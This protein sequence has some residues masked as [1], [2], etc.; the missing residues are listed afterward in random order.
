MRAV[1]VVLMLALPSSVP[2]QQLPSFTD[3]YFFGASN[4]DT[5]NFLNHP[6]WQ[7]QPFA[8]IPARGYWMGRWQSG[9]AWAEFFA[10]ALG[11]SAIASSNGGTNYAFG[12]A[13][14]SPHP[15][16]T[17]AAPGTPAH[18]LYFSTQIDQILADEGG[19]LDSGALYVIAIGDNDPPI[20][21]RTPAQAP[22]A[23]AVVITQM[24]RLRAAGARNFLVRTLPPGQDPY[25][26]PFNAA[27]LQGVNTLR[28][29]GAVVFVV[30]AASFVQ[31]RLT[32]AYLA[33]IGIT[34]FGNCRANPACQAGATA[35]ALA[36]QVFNHQF[37]FFDSV[38]PHFNHAVHLEIARHALLSLGPGT[39]AT[40]IP[41]LSPG[42]MALL[43]ALL[44]FSALFMMRLWK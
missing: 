26:T 29:S 44:A 5:G 42:T 23:A 17:P 1:L 41:T 6:H 35:A 2:A 4:L 31:Q 36:G 18:A 37:L 24:E 20:F 27:L 32:V 7:T 25:A 13:G 30:D 28:A 39:A 3:V 14:T 8:P 21:G 16:E 38:G 9:P 11:R 34:D 12:A 33:G 40:G 19:I 22:T 15:G 43:A 10:Q